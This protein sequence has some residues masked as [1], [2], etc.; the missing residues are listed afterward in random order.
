[1]RSSSLIETR[2]VTADFR[3]RDIRVSEEMYQALSSLA[4]CKGP[5]GRELKTR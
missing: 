4:L 5:A 3:I 2:Q 1:M